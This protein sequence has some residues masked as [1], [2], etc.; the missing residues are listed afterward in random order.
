MDIS[1]V[2][3]ENPSLAVELIHNKYDKY[4]K[5]VAYKNTNDPSIVSDLVQDCYMKWL[6]ET[7]NVSNV[8]SYITLCV[9]NHSI[10]EMDYSS[11]HFVKSDIDLTEDMVYS[12]VNNIDIGLDSNYL[13]YVFHN[14]IDEIYNICADR[15]KSVLELKMSGYSYR[16]IS[17]ILGVSIKTVESTISKL[18]KKCRLY[19]KNM[20]YYNDI[21]GAIEYKKDYYG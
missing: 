20:P 10:N 14:T 13:N 17:D 8:K 21:R 3:L 1:K 2:W 19:F 15:Q 7:P 16:E 18:Y 12:N 9:I 6:K 4:L 11:R 5:Y